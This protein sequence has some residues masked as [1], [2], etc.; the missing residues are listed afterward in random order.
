MIIKISLF[1]ALLALPV[2][3]I[4]QSNIRYSPTA[5]FRSLDGEPGKFQIAKVLS[6]TDGMKYYY[7]DEAGHDSYPILDDNNCQ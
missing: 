1:L 2:S 3:S 4:F 7:L 5:D 6:P